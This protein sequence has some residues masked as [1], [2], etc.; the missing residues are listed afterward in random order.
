MLRA[1]ASNIDLSKRFGRTWARLLT[2][3]L[4]EFLVLM[5]GGSRELEG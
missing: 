2:G 3:V 1:G 4:P 5:V